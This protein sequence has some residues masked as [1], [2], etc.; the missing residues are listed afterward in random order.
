MDIIVLGFLMMQRATLYELRQFV[1]SYLTSISSNSLGSIQA[2]IKKLLK[3]DMISYYEY[4]DNGV[5]K[6]VYSINDLGKAYL[7][8]CLSSPML[9]KEKNME[10]S[11][12]FFMGFISKEKQQASI[13]NYIQELDKE[14][15][16]LQHV[17]SLLSPRYVINEAS[18]KQLEEKGGEID[19]ANKDQLKSIASFQYATLDLGIEKLEFEIAWFKKFKEQVFKEDEE[20]E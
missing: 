18:L 16:F 6:K 11:K 1:E 8:E 9:Y 20:H 2:A 12:F 15:Q 17:N 7:E 4:V 14:L 3:N 19:L 5:N 10:L 13:E